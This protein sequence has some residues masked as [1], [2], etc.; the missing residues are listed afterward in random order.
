MLTG[1]RS[2]NLEMSIDRPQRKNQGLRKPVFTFLRA[3]SQTLGEGKAKEVVR[4]VILQ[5][6]Q[7]VPR[8]F[9]I[10][11]GDVVIQVGT[12][13]VETIERIANCIGPNG[14]A[15]II[16]PEQANVIRLRKRLKEIACNNIEVVQKA[17]WHEA[18]HLEFLVSQKWSGN[19]RLK[20]DAIVHDNDLREREEGGDYQVT[21]VEADTVENIARQMNIHQANYIEITVNGAEFQVLQGVG[22]LLQ[23]TK[24]LFVKGH[25]REKGSQQPINIKI[26]KFLADHGFQTQRTKPVRSHSQEWGVKEGDVYGWR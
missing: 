9:M 16:E 18:S 3:C 10:N 23:Q 21:W 7:N 13:Q 8:E 17:A 26:Q 22:A 19:H 1:N 20:N 25:A 6:K 4:R 11:R 24:R 14:R 2:Q 15:I 12:P 5:Y